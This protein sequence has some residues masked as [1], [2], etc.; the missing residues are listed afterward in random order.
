MVLK[1]VTANL[2]SEGTVVWMTADGGWADRIEDAA[3]FEGADA[4]AALK[5]AEADFKRVI[6]AYLIEIDPG[7][8]A[9]GQERLKE[10]IRA[11]GPTVRPD[12][13]KQA[14]DH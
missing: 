9:V 12:L 8:G 6:S 7:H 14:G 5:R 11:Q 13:G 3:A 10:T 2:L 1:T 4:D